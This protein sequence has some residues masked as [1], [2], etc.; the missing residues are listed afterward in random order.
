MSNFCYIAFAFSRISL[1]GK[2][3]SKLVEYIS[4]ASLKKYILVT[5][6]ISVGL[7]IVKG[8]KYQINYIHSERDYPFLIEND[9]DQ[10]GGKWTKNLY[11]VVNFVSD[12]LNYVIFVVVNIIIDIYMVSRLRKT[13]H[14]KLDRLM[15]NHEN[16][17][18]QQKNSCKMNKK[19]EREIKEAIN[20][21]IRMVF[22]NS[23]LNFY[24]K[25]PLVYIPLH[26][27]IYT[28][29]YSKTKSHGFDTL[30]ATSDNFGFDTYFRHMTQMDLITLVSDFADWLLGVLIFIQFFV[31]LKFDKKLKEAF[32]KLFTS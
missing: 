9:L 32:E 21:A 3:H 23:A 7:S 4:K 8:F 15:L 17:V 1:I 5:S 16:D 26:N 13:L 31:F 22:V 11:N 14:E 12:I 19:K 18:S 6:L 2:E 20:N 27:V 28:F 30:L 10:T 29:Y 25:L 24:L